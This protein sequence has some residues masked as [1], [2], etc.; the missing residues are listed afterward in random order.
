M[1]LVTDYLDSRG[2]P[3][4]LL[5]HAPTTT[6]VEEAGALHID[7][8]HVLKAVVI[9]TRCRDLVAVIPASRLLDI[10]LVRQA[11]GDPNAHLATEDE[12]SSRATS[13]RSSLE[14][15][16]SSAGCSTPRRSSIRPCS[17]ATRSCSPRAHARTRCACA[18]WT[19]SAAS[20]R[21]SRGS[22]S[23]RNRSRRRRDD[24]DT[25]TRGERRRVNRAAAL[26]AQ[27]PADL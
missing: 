18:R 22:R 8:D 12:L 24:A 5:H 7:V 14:V 23:S 4:E 1:S 21:A 2:V 13:R 16:P 6:C 10:H 9:D 3:Y 20:T 19:S 27:G 11:L 25:F 17:T 26:T 15:C